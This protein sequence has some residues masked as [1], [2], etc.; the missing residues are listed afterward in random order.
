MKELKELIEIYQM[1]NRRQHTVIKESMKEMI[2]K[3]DKI[4]KLLTDK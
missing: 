2:K 4:E 3:L 1:E